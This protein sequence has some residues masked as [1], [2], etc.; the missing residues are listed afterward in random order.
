M[1]LNET[2]NIVSVEFGITR[3]KYYARFCLFLQARFGI[4][5]SYTFKRKSFQTNLEFE[6]S[7]RSESSIERNGLILKMNSDLICKARVQYHL[8]YV[9]ASNLFFF[10][11]VDLYYSRYQPMDIR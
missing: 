1:C 10:F 7:L 4:I 11:P 2:R 5:W 3:E 6:S 8:I 9:I